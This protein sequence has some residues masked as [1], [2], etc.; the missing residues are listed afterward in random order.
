[1]LITN[2][3]CDD[4]HNKMC[5]GKITILFA[6]RKI[7]IFNDDIRNKLKIIV[8]GE[9]IEDFNEVSSWL[10]V[11]QTIAKHLKISLKSAQVEVSVYHPS[12]GV[13]VKVPSQKYAGKMEGLCGDCNRTPRNDLKLPNGELTTDVEEFGLSWLYDKIPGNDKETCKPVKEKPCQD[14]QGDDPCL[15]L[16]DENI[17][18]LVR[19]KPQTYI[20]A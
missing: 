14:I 7:H 12:L 4:A 1:M 15:L 3:P 6:G 18:D 20:Y 2:K 8:D 9:R 5:V 11:K 10:G 13:S 16:L 17:F 19:I